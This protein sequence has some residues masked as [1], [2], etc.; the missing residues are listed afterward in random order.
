MLG[1][2]GE[3]THADIV[4][5]ALCTVQLNTF[6]R[7]P[8]S[9]GIPNRVWQVVARVVLRLAQDDICWVGGGGGS[10]WCD[11]EWV[12]WRSVEPE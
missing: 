5:V 9:F 11:G 8:V 4:C 12:I 1:W 7:R 3:F 10:D 6:A 2:A